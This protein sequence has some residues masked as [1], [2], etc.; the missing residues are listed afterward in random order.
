MTPLVPARPRSSRTTR[1]VFVPV[2]IGT[3]TDAWATDNL[4]SSRPEQDPNETGRGVACMHDSRTEDQKRNG[5]HGARKATAITTRRV[6]AGDP[7]VYIGREPDG[8]F[9]VFDAAN[10]WTLTADDLVAI[11]SH[12]LVESHPEAQRGL[13]LAYAYGSAWRDDDGKWRLVEDET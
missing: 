8:N 12:C 11:C 9:A 7:V 1:H 6:M 2:P 3:G 5:G 10:P 4:S 13:E